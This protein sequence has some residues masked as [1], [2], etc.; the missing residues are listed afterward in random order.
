MEQSDCFND[1]KGGLHVR[2]EQKKSVLVYS[3][4]NFLFNVILAFYTFQDMILQNS[5]QPTSVNAKAEGQG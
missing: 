2:K 5:G 4:V 3:G 1:Q